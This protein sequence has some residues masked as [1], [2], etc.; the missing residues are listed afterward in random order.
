MFVP[1]EQPCGAADE[2][3]VSRQHSVSS[4]QHAYTVHVIYAIN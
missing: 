4:D 3:V 2:L 1:D